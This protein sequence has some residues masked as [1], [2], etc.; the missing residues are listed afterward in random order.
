MTAIGI[1]AARRIN[2]STA[3][4]CRTKVRTKTASNNR[5]FKARGRTSALLIV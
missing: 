3:A 2:L 4:P 5:A 1:N